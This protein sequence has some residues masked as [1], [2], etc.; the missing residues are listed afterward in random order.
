GDHATLFTSSNGLDWAPRSVP[1]DSFSTISDVCFGNGTYVAVSQYVLTSTDGI[2]WTSSGFQGG[3]KIA[4]GNGRFVLSVISYPGPVPYQY[5]YSSA[6]GSNWT[7]VCS[8][9]AGQPGQPAPL[10]VY[11][12]KGFLLTACFQNAMSGNG[13]NWTNVSPGLGYGNPGGPSAA[14]V[15]FG[16]GRYVAVGAYG[17]LYPYYLTQGG[18]A[19][20]TSDDGAN[21][22]SR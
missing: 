12:D 22:L 3:S 15:A 1:V 11:G 4:F 14:A 5:G 7:Q 2:L 13:V 19:I 6:N 9:S 18:G 8:L 21:W 16:S 10:V 20:F 17:D